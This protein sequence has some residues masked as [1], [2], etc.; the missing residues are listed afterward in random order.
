MSTNYTFPFS[1]CERYRTI[2]AQPFSSLVNIII[3]IFLIYCLFQA[4]S[5]QLKYVFMSFILF[6]LWH[7]LSHMMFIPGTIQQSAV[8]L[9]AYNIAFGTLFALL[10]F[11]KSSLNLYQIIILIVVVIL[12]ITIF[13]MYSSSDG[14]YIILSG[15]LLFMVVLSCL[16]K[17]YSTF[18]L[19]YII[20]LLGLA[21]LFV[22][23]AINCKWMLI[24]WPNFPFHIFIEIYGLGLFYV[25]SNKLLSLE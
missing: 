4:K 2:I 22:N 5:I 25:L 19:Y 24:Q 13:V 15:T 11:S 16:Y 3:V 18:V 10:H 6:E 1:T 20:G 21:L 9:L 23:E 8:H 17:K 7:T 14:I 12:D